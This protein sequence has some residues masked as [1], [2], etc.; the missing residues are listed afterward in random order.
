MNFSIP[1]TVRGTDLHASILPTIAT[2]TGLIAT[3]FPFPSGA[4][5]VDQVGIEA[6]SACGRKIQ[7]TEKSAPKG[8]RIWPALRSG[9]PHRKFSTSIR[10][11]TEESTRE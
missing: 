9:E 3:A 5:A 1:S 8:W 7:E 10:S 4:S 6:G 11:S 2:L